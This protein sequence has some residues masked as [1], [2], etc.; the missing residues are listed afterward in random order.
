MSLRLTEVSTEESWRG[1]TQEP[2]G[3]STWLSE[4]VRP[5]R[6]IRVSNRH[7]PWETLRKAPNRHLSLAWYTSYSSSLA[8]RKTQASTTSPQRAVKLLSVNNGENAETTRTDEHRTRRT[9]C[10]PTCENLSAASRLPGA[11]EHMGGCFG[12]TRRASHGHSSRTA[13]RHQGFGPLS[14]AQSV[15][16][17]PSSWGISLSSQGKPALFLLWLLNILSIPPNTLNSLRI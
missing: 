8:E 15:P 11:Q 16:L 10:G 9:R 17:L 3:P 13:L 4:W 2:E 6:G 5:Q 12:P 7:W 14:E 1:R